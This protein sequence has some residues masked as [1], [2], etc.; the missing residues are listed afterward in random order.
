[1]QT[2]FCKNILIFIFKAL[3]ILNA[4]FNF[5]KFFIYT[6]TQKHKNIKTQKHKTPQ[7]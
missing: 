6:K 7:F 4:D 3:R 2:Y 1:M 5:Y